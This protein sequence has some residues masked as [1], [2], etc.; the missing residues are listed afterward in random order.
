[1]T[2]NQEDIVDKGAAL[3]RSPYEILT[4]A[5]IIEKEARLPEDRDRISRVIHNRLF[6]TEQRA[7]GFFADDLESF[8]LQ[9][10]SAVLYGR[11]QEGLDPD[12]P[13]SRIR[14]IPTDWNTYILPGLPLTP[15]TTP[16][17]ESVDAALN[18][19]PNPIPTDPI[20]IDL[21]EPDDCFLFFYAL[22]GEDGSMAFAATG[23]QH[24]ANVERARDSGLL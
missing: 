19:A 22:T 21:P 3:G 20:C 24:E 7:G 9:V 1:M 16:S 4:L 17:Q 8:P 14:T 2:G 23:E 6:V 13:F 15:I 11:D 18:P 10:D 5:S 12:L